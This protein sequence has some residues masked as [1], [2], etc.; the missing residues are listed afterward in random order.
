VAL[1]LSRELFAVSDDEEYAAA[2]GMPVL[3]LNV[4]LALMTA[5]TVVVSMRVVGLLLISALMVVPVAIAQLVA[6]SFRATLLTAMTL[7]VLVAVTGVATSFY[8][9]TPTGGT[10]VLL[11]IGIFVVATAAVAVRRRLRSR[12]GARPRRAVPLSAGTGAS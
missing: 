6:G 12:A 8:A 2:A 7:G 9:D 11:A 1:G 10:I 5:L 4:A 3:R